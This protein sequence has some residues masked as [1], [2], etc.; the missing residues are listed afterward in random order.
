MLW[1]LVAGPRRRR[2]ARSRDLRV[3]RRGLRPRARLGDP[4]PRWREPDLAAIA[5]ALVLVVAAFRPSTC[6]SPRSWPDRARAAPGD[7]GAV[8][9]AR[10]KAASSDDDPPGKQRR[11]RAAVS[12]AVQAEREGRLGRRVRE[13]V[14]RRRAR[15]I[16]V[17][18]A[19]N[20]VACSPQTWLY[21]PTL[22]P[23][24][25]LAWACSPRPAS[26]RARAPVPRRCPG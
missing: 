9:V 21:T 13:P 25:P 3:L 12:S 24:T 26:A 20:S 5:F 18:V 14:L 19:K 6:S 10:L 15:R 23:T 2:H 22:T 7:P 8:H 1:A 16:A 17:P 11:S 4:D